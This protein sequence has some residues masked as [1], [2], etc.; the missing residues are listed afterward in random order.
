VFVNQVDTS[1]G[2]V[3]E[4]G[5]EDEYQL[6]EVEVTA[7][8]YILKTPVSNFRN[9]WDTLDSELERVDEYSL[10][11]RENLQEAV[12]AVTAILGMQPCE[13]G[14]LWVILCLD[15]IVIYYAFE[16][17]VAFWYI[18][19]NLTLKTGNIDILVCRQQMSC[20]AMRDPTLAY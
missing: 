16:L 13:V 15:V 9:A 19:V 14:V 10:G 8:D 17:I 3:D 18:W 2:E 4:D 20:L 5:Y 12:Q 7:S 11:A 1:T 6:E